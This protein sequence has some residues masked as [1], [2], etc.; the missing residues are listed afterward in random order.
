MQPS[1]VA[2]SSAPSLEKS[3]VID[4]SAPSTLYAY[5]T[6]ERGLSGFGG[7]SRFLITLAPSSSPGH[8]RSLKSL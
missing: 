6:T 3:S 2:T 7:F 4:P 5:P 1:P 8:T